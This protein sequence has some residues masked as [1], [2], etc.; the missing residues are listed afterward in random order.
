[1]LRVLTIAGLAVATPLL[2]GCTGTWDT[3]TSRN[4][5]KDPFN[6]TYHMWHPED[7]MVVL[8]ADPPR[9]GDERAKAMLRLKEPLAIGLSQRDQDEVVDMLARTAT[10]DASPVLRIAAIEALGRF[11][12]ARAPAILMTAYQKSH[13]RP[14][15]VPDPVQPPPAIQLT[16]GSA[17]RMPGRAASTIPFTGPTGFAPDTVEAIQCRTLES[18]GRTSRAEV[19][20]FL[21]SVA[22]GPKGDSAPAGADDRDVRLA[23]VRG[24]GRCRQPEAVVALAQVLAAEKGKDTAIIGRAHD[25]L[26]H[27]TGKHLPADPQKWDAVVQAGVAIAPEPNWVENAVQNTVSWVKQQ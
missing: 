15:G 21:A 1:V 9:D 13:G 25:G 16:G 17:G 23:A 5:R 8:R 27:L 3:I 19:V 22:V 11:E 14:E 12:D 6:T 24:L 20:S 18:L 4:F 7:P 10:K 2:T 26:V